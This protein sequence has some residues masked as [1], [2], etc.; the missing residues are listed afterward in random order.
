MYLDEVLL[1]KALLLAGRD[2]LEVEA[3]T[4]G[5]F[6]VLWM[7]FDSPPPPKGDTHDEALELFIKWMEAKNEGNNN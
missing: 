1:N 7:S 6:V 4:D 5:K 2:E 3:T